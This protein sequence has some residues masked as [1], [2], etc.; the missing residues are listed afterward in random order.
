MY[1]SESRQVSSYK[2]HR[3]AVSES[4]VRL[5]LA[6]DYVAARQRILLLQVKIKAEIVRCN[7]QSA[8]K[9]HRA[10]D[11]TLLAHGIIYTRALHRE[12]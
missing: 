9:I 1:I 5:V 3:R 8:G 12:F 2:S 11:A 4:F 7:L 6:F 10:R